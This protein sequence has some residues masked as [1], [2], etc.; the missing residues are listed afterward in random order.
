MKRE[1]EDTIPDAGKVSPKETTTLFR[2]KVDYKGDNKE[3]IYGSD[4]SPSE[5]DGCVI[6]LTKE[7]EN[8]DNE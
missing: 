5:T 3:K 2:N 7:Y 4:D 6:N 1:T 8:E